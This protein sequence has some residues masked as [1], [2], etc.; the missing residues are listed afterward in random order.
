MR[1]LLKIIA[2]GLSSCKWVTLY[3]PDRPQGAG[4]A[5]CPHF[6]EKRNAILASHF[7]VEVLQ[8]LSVVAHFILNHFG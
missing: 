3:F 8:G 2:A 7:G 1:A 5:G 4:P 6:S